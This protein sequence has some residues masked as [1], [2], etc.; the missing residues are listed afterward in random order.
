MIPPKSQNEDFEFKRIPQWQYPARLFSIVDIGTHTSVGKFGEKRKR[1]VRLTFEFPTALETF[2]EERGPEPFTVMCP[3]TYSMNG[4]SNLRK[5]IESMIGRQLSDDEADNFDLETLMGK[6]IFANVAD[7]KSG[8]KTFSNI[9]V[10]MPLPDAIEC[11]KPFFSPILYTVENHNELMYQ[12][13]SKKVQEKI[14]SAEEMQI[15]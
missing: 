4:K 9:I 1:L 8:D 2:V 12:K 13:L 6:T 3:F 5:F 15:G 7:V 14:A 10:C 11:P